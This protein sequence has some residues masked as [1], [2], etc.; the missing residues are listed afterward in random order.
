MGVAIHKNDCPKSQKSRGSYEGHI[1][2]G[3]FAKFH[4]LAEDELSVGANV[5]EFRS[6]AQTDSAP[7]RAVVWRV[8]QGGR[9]DVLGGLGCGRE[10]QPH[11]VRRRRGVGLRIRPGRPAGRGRERVPALRRQPGLD[12]RPDARLRQRRDAVREAVR[13]V[14]ARRG[15]GRHRPA[16]DAVPG[17]GRGGSRS[18]PPAGRHHVG[19]LDRA[20]SLRRL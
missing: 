2:D 10:P 3:R 1:W 8:V 12:L 17:R 13:L 14:A 19:T 20:C 4:D 7:G 15:A 9:R 6:G 5:L 11:H 18:R 16:R